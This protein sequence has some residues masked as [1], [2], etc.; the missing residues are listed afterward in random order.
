DGPT[1]VMNMREAFPGSVEDILHSV[2]DEVG[3]QNFFFEMDEAAKNGPLS[4]YVGQ[5]AI[6]VVYDP[7]WET[8]GNYV[9]TALSKRYDAFVF[10][11][12]TKAL[13]PLKLYFDPH[14]IPETWPRVND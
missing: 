13:T 11:D 9:T 5:Q 3:H 6:G 12:E 8:P 7:R 10:L 1:E 14:K 4:Q 2:V